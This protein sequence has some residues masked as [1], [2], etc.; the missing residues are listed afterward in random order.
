MALSRRKYMEDGKRQLR[1][2]LS[3]IEEQEEQ[4]HQYLSD[5]VRPATTGARKLLRETDKHRFHRN[6]QDVSSTVGKCLDMLLW[7]SAMLPSEETDT[8][9]NEGSSHS[10]SSS[11]TESKSGKF[12]LPAS[13]VSKEKPPRS[14]HKERQDGA[15][16]DVKNAREVHTEKE[17]AQQ[18]KDGGSVSDRGPKKCQAQVAQKEMSKTSDE[19]K[20]EHKLKATKEQSKSECKDD[21]IR[22]K[23]ASTS[24]INRSTSES[25][26]DMQDKGK[27]SAV[28]E[29]HT[30]HSKEVSN[31]KGK[32]SVRPEK[33]ACESSQK[34]N[35]DKKSQK[36]SGEETKNKTSGEFGQK[37]KSVIPERREQAVRVENYLRKTETGKNFRDEFSYYRN[38]GYGSHYGSKNQPVP[39]RKDSRLGMRPKARSTPRKVETRQSPKHV[40]EVERITEAQVCPS[41]PEVWSVEESIFCDADTP[42]KV[43]SSPKMNR[44]REQIQR[45]ESPGETISREKVQEVFAWLEKSS[46]HTEEQRPDGDHSKRNTTP[47]SEGHVIYRRDTKNANG[48]KPKEETFKKMKVEADKVVK[49]ESGSD[50]GKRVS[51]NILPQILSESS[52]VSSTSANSVETNG[53]LHTRDKATVNETSRSKLPDDCQSRRKNDEQSKTAVTNKTKERNLDDI[54][55]VWSE[56]QLWDDD[57]L[58]QGRCDQKSKPGNQKQKNTHSLRDKSEHKNVKSDDKSH[59]HPEKKDKRPITDQSAVRIRDWDGRSKTGSGEEGDTCKQGK[60]FSPHP[61]AQL[62]DRVPLDT[63]G[64]NSG[65]EKQTQE[66]KQAL[67]KQFNSVAEGK[68]DFL[69][70]E[71][72]ELKGN[73]ESCEKGADT[74]LA[75]CSENKKVLFEK[76]ANQES[77]QQH[78]L[79]EKLQS[80]NVVP[81]VDTT[82][83]V[84]PKTVTAP[85]I[86]DGTTTVAN[87]TP[88]P[89]TSSKEKVST[90]NKQGTFFEAKGAVALMGPLVSA[91]T[92]HDGSC[93]D[94]FV[95]DVISPNMFWVQP[96]KSSLDRLVEEMCIFYYQLGENDERLSGVPS[97][98]M[99]LAACFSKD[100][101]W[102][103]GRVLAVHDVTSTA[104]SEIKS[105][106]C[107]SGCIS[108]SQSVCS[109]SSS[110]SD[111]NSSTTEVDLLYVDYGNRERLPLTRLRTLNEQFTKLP[112]QAVCCCLAQV[113]PP[114]QVGVWKE[115]EILYFS[116]L[117]YG[118]TLQG[119]ISTVPGSHLFSIDLSFMLVTA[120]QVMDGSTS[121]GNVPVMKFNVGDLMVQSGKAKKVEGV[122]DM[123]TV[124]EVIA[125]PRSSEIRDIPGTV[126]EEM[127]KP[128]AEEGAKEP[129]TAGNTEF[130]TN[131]DFIL[132]ADKITRPEQLRAPDSSNQQNVS[133]FPLTPL[134][135]ESDSYGQD[136]SF[137]CSSDTSSEESLPDREIST[138]CSEGDHAVNGPDR[139]MVEP[140]QAEKTQ[141]QCESK[142]MDAADQDDS[143]PDSSEVAAVCSGVETDSTVEVDLSCSEI[144]KEEKPDEV[145]MIC[146][147][148]RAPLDVSSDGKL[149]VVMSHIVSPGEFYVHLVSVQAKRFD[150]FLEELNDVY[151]GFQTR[152]SY[153][154]KVG[155]VCCIHY[156]EDEKWYRAEVKDVMKNQTEKGGA[157]DTMVTVFYVDFGNTEVVAACDIM[158]L[159]LNFIDFPAQ[160]VKCHLSEIDPIHA[161]LECRDTEEYDEAG[162]PSKQAGKENLTGG[163]VD[164]A[165]NDQFSKVADQCEDSQ[166]GDKEAPDLNCNEINCVHVV[167]GQSC[168]GHDQGQTD[169]QTQDDSEVNVDENHTDTD[170]QALD[171][172]KVKE[173]ED[174]SQEDPDGFRSDSQSKQSSADNQHVQPTWSE[175]SVLAFEGLTGYTS[176][177]LSEN[178]TEKDGIVSVMLTN[179][180]GVLINQELVNLGL[181]SSKTLIKGKPVTEVYRR[182]DLAN[183]SGSSSG[184]TGD[185]DISG[186]DMKE[187]DPMSM[188]YLSDTNSYQVD[189]DDPGVATIGYKAK[190]TRICRFFS[191]GETCYRGE[192]CPYEHSLPGESS[193]DKKETF[194]SNKHVA[195]PKEDSW[196]A[197]EVT[198][199]YSPLHF[200][201]QLPF[202]NKS[203]DQLKLEAEG[204][205]PDSGVL[206]EDEDDS[207][208]ID[209]LM[210]K[211]NKL[212]A[213]SV[214]RDTD[215]LLPA[216]GEIV[217]AQYS[218]DNRW[219]R[220][221][222]TDVQE[223]N[224]DVTLEVFYVDYG[225]SEWLSITSI[226]QIQEE[227]LRLPF[228]AVECFLAGIEPTLEEGQSWPEDA[229]KL[230]EEETVNKRLIGHIKYRTGSVL[231]VDLYCT[232]DDKEV[233]VNKLLVEHGYAQERNWTKPTRK[234]QSVGVIKSAGKEVCMKPG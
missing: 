122:L 1:M 2:K 203:L 49:K 183:Q 224:G 211:L 135:G 161:D 55:I 21:S 170:G 164:S 124:R 141:E 67:E 102:Y 206:S 52:N 163:D 109:T 214:Y 59:I 110:S 232:E 119:V 139:V 74:T 89:D 33:N 220:A 46:K 104:I 48:K 99:M 159:D 35:I 95:T 7:I 24:P 186:S 130:H 140:S 221:L 81:K 72:T 51:R 146:Q 179:S 68:C 106:K 177:L 27:A 181:A 192:T 98:G 100:D 31:E 56:V 202:G 118:K 144:A 165:D 117:V 10:S 91:L 184:V 5:L 103:R 215:L 90:S 69:T 158:P 138:Q 219:Y 65:S 115:D 85:K 120:P 84:K 209:P 3:V 167:S 40:A 29:R 137:E 25:K 218:D 196:V 62:A 121:S 210:E 223:Q 60:D 193:N 125:E 8:E 101:T 88:E 233:E 173:G 36:I 213:H 231:H 198:A 204:S 156:G 34:C 43:R 176:L 82:A 175:D 38:I 154:P 147:L 19:S 13:T 22:K 83:A 149:R 70:A 112:C 116:N 86:A 63:I 180:E 132:E 107:G 26:V 47:H 189:V 199:I 78:I 172:G 205:I 123:S 42:E 15:H 178:W 185:L 148:E 9:G 4:M 113:C 94:V 234:R 197:V 212:Y 201:V 191:Q 80:Q 44:S 169:G 200:W 37:E 216:R 61:V 57:H 30:S 97:V 187:W 229:L 71:T 41:D 194:H 143:A 134:L 131:R 230:F 225:N 136:L 114:E 12:N 23:D 195:L 151:S 108:P 20:S 142:D 53:K 208:L 73:D 228:Q 79:S 217:V 160:A 54:D 32:D 64:D 152:D 188:H 155:E 14:G 128:T 50:G 227:F 76:P 150:Y 105:P 157:I 190:E 207:F 166:T 18:K 126:W 58:V 182:E 111:G 28:Q 127:I 222:V 77:S 93:I 226:R 92:F 174:Q 153:V 129:K 17:E 171:D 6:Y 87:H 11:E 75:M 162:I 66:E 45:E 39:P 133:G 96:V 168:L 16:E 145:C